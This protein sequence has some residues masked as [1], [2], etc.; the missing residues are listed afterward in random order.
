MSGNILEDYIL[1][2]N[3]IIILILGFPCSDKSTI[4]KELS[5]DTKLK[6]IN[7]NN[8]IDDDKYV[9]EKI[10]GLTLKMY[11]HPD[12][13][14][15]NKLNK[16]VNKHKKKGIILYGNYIDI[17]KINFDLNFVF[18]ININNLL[19]TKILFEKKMFPY[20]E[21]NKKVS[22]YFKNYLN[23]L[24]EK[25]KTDIKINKYFNVKEDTVLNDVYEKLFDILMSLISSN[26]KIKIDK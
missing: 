15:W 1:R 20:E 24:Y 6:K 4:A 21:D 23:P 9:I 8:Y 22:I 25:L 7:I 18:F 12:N 14:N 13:Y 10:N 26:L 2:N 11:E 16:D 5:I 3:Q 17:N 19:C